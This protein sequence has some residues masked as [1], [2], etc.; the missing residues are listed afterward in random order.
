MDPRSI[1]VYDFGL[2][3]VLDE[4]NRYATEDCGSLGYTAPEL[5]RREQY[6]V[7]VDMFSTGVII[8]FILSGYRPFNIPGANRGTVKQRIINCEYTLHTDR[9]NRVSSEAQ[10]LVRGLLTQRYGDS[11][12]LNVEEAVAHA[13]LGEDEATVYEHGQRNLDENAT[14]IEIGPEWEPALSHHSIQS[15]SSTEYHLISVFQ[16]SSLTKLKLFWQ[17]I[18]AVPVDPNVKAILT[19]IE[20]QQIG[21][22]QFAFVATEMN[23]A[24]VPLLDYVVKSQMQY[25]ERRCRHMFLKIFQAFQTLHLQNVVHRSIRR[26]HIYVQVS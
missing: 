7:E 2:A 23:I 19:Q 22:G 20:Q 17:T 3:K 8:F 16:K 15:V 13:W 14:Q 1:K 12:R 11:P 25:T 5:L 21:V 4:Q 9:W 24:A 18:P 6:G 10:S 26:E